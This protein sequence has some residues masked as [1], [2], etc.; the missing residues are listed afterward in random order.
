MA[1]AMK[2][3][4]APSMKTLDDVKSD[5]SEL[6]EQVKNGETDLKLAGELANITGK[7][8]KAAQLELAREVFLSNNPDNRPR[9]A[10]AV[11]RP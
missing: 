5:M 4:R 11:S 1:T 9:I 2:I 8:L 6:Y 7:Y 10:S 3:E